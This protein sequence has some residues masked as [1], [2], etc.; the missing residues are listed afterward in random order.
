MILC[1][2]DYGLYFVVVGIDPYITLYTTKI[3]NMFCEPRTSAIRIQ[4]HFVV[5]YTKAI[6]TLEILRNRVRCSPV[7]AVFAVSAF[8]GVA[9]IPK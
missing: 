9:F 7:T 4:D 6:S 1:P 2:V 5:L 3:L 8:Y